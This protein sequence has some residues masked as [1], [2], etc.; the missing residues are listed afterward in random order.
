[1]VTNQIFQSGNKLAGYSIEYSSKGF[2]GIRD[3]RKLLNRKE[4]AKNE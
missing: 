4:R 3:F 2:K 1:M